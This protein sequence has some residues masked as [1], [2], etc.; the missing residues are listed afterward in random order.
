MIP[1]GS[2][3]VNIFSVHKVYYRFSSK[4]A[5]TIQSEGGGYRKRHF[6]LPEVTMVTE[7]VALYSQSRQVTENV[8]STARILRT[9][10]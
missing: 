1:H 5:S 3:R 4:A 6:L 9:G 7:I 2:S 8:A 10:F